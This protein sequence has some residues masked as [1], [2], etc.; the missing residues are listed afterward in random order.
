MRAWDYS[1]V[2]VHYF[3]EGMNRVHLSNLQC[4]GALRITAAEMLRRPA[5]LCGQAGGA[6]AQCLHLP[7]LYSSRTKVYRDFVCCV[8]GRVRGGG[9]VH[10]AAAPVAN[11]GV[12]RKSP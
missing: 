12:R 1:G 3:V 10:V 11:L 4:V 8:G 9:C 5:H 7:Y 2:N 6:F